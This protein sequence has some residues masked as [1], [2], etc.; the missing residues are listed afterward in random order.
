MISMSLTELPVFLSRNSQVFFAFPL[1]ML[2]STIKVP[3]GKRHNGFLEAMHVTHS[4]ESIAIVFV[5]L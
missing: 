1:L 3:R 4:V 5:I 2:I